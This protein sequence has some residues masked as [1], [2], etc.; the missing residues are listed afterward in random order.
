MAVAGYVCH[1][2]Q[3]RRSVP[4]QGSG[5]GDVGIVRRPRPPPAR[6]RTVRHLARRSFRA[7]RPTDSRQQPHQRVV[8]RR[9]PRR[10]AHR[11]GRP[12]SRRP[13]PRLCRTGLVALGGDARGRA[14]R[15][16]AG[17]GVAALRHRAVPGRA[18]RR[19]RV[20]AEQPGHQREPRADAGDL[21]RG[22]VRRIR[23][24]S[25]PVVRRRPARHH[26]V[27][28]RQHH[29]VAGRRAGGPVGGRDAAGGRS[30]REHI[31]LRDLAKVVPTGVG[32]CLLVGIAHGALTGMAAIYATR[33]GMSTGQIGL[34]VAAPNIGGMLLHWPVSAASDD[35]DRR[36]VGLAASLG[37]D[38]APRRCCC[39][40][41]RPARWRCC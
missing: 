4:H 8:L 40:D 23:D 37:A 1:G 25:G 11:P 7:G 2:T 34:F 28:H 32:S 16:R 12:R 24:R 15:V 9:V 14:H 38:P 20:V 17:V 41:R 18:V 13:H 31:S 21:R 27:R 29:H 3:R 35:I 5:S 30:E 39:S 33:V 19:R 36:A 10:V 22:H 26:R 6:R